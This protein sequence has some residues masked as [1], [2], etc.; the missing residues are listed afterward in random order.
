MKWKIPS[1]ETRLYLIA[2]IVLLGGLGG[3]IVIYLMAGNTPDLT[4]I[5]DFE[6]S[7]RYRHDLELY[8]GKWNVLA[9]EFMRWFAG[10]W[11]GKS[12]AF[13]IACITILVSLGLFVFARYMPHLSYD[14]ESDGQ[15]ET[16]SDR[17]DR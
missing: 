1:L 9:D 6:N 4:L 16:E 15:G 12:L 7:K 11:H 17:S 14:P 5:Q 2:A 10:F 3:A 13:T 8:G